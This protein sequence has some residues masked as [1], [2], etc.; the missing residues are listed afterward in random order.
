M[1][2]TSF[3]ARSLMCCACLTTLDAVPCDLPGVEKET[4]EC[5]FLLP[6]AA[7]Q[8]LVSELEDKLACDLSTAEQ[9]IA[10]APRHNWAKYD[11]C[12]IVTIPTELMYTTIMKS[13]AKLSKQSKSQVQSC[14]VLGLTQLNPLATVCH[15]RTVPL[16]QYLV[17]PDAQ[18]FP[19]VCPDL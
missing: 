10:A 13:F 16:H 1:Q 8:Q 17:S 5:H 4:W 11:S 19:Y 12:Q 14:K 15:Y 6:L 18:L 7:A 3:G 9:A 2:H